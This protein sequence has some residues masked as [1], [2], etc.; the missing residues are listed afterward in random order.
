MAFWGIV[1]ITV[2][3]V[4]AYNLVKGMYSMYC[5]AEH[6]KDQY[7][8]HQNTTE[9]YRR[10]HSTYHHLLTESQYHRCEGEFVVLNKSCIIDPYILCRI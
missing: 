7:R 6:I 10:T 8:T 2:S 5:D 1:E 3:A 4:G 9:Q